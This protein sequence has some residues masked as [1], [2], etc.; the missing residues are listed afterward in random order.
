MAFRKPS[1]DSRLQFSFRF[2]LLALPLQVGLIDICDAFIGCSISENAVDRL[3][4]TIYA[5]SSPLPPLKMAHPYRFACS[6]IPG[7][8]PDQSMVA[9][10][11]FRTP[12]DGL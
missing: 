4:R 9:P 2:F 8:G 7:T 6:N 12:L 10:Y 1:R 11:S 5:R 3:D